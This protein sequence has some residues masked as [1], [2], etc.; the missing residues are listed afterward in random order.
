MSHKWKPMFQRMGG[1]KVGRSFQ[2]VPPMKTIVSKLSHKWKP[3]FQRLGGH[4]GGRISPLWRSQGCPGN[5]PLKTRFVNF[6]SI[7]NFFS[8]CLSQLPIVDERECQRNLEENGVNFSRGVICAGTSGKGTCHVSNLFLCLW[9]MKCS[10][11]SYSKEIL[12]F[13]GTF[14]PKESL[15]LLI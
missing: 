7:V 15:E 5:F 8:L 11:N 9:K 2:V 4:K 13:L 3:M 6:G 10:E 14:T 1:D 12:R